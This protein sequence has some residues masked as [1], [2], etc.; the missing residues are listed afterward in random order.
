[1]AGPSTMGPSLTPPWSSP[2]APLPAITQP[3]STNLVNHQLKILIDI[4]RKLDYTTITLAIIVIARLGSFLFSDT[5]LSDWKVGLI[6]LIL[7]LLVLCSC[8]IGIVKILNSMMKGKTS[9]D[10]KPRGSSIKTRYSGSHWRCRPCCNIFFKLPILA[11][12]DWIL[13]QSGIFSVG[14]DRL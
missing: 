12:I 14:F 13:R 10:F 11:Q 2:T 6:L 7:S 8:L 3:Q 5:G 9:F 1:M 4:F